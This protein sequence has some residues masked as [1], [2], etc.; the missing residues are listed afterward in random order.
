MSQR[1][2]GL[3]ERVRK[4]L[5]FLRFRSVLGR[6]MNDESVERGLR[7]LCGDSASQSSAGQDVDAIKSFAEKETGLPSSCVEEK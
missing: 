3:I 7:E 1:T 6:W 5:G 4:E 2:P